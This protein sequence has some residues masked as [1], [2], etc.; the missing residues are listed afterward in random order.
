MVDPLLN[1]FQRFVTVVLFFAK[2]KEHDFV[3]RRCVDKLKQ[4]LGDV[5][6]L[7]MWTEL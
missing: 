3:H 5:R 4:L 6:S 7:L 1:L 2:V